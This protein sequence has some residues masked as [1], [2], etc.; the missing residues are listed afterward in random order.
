M[1]YLIMGISFLLLVFVA[2]INIRSQSVK[3]KIHASPHNQKVNNEDKDT[4]LIKMAINQSSLLTQLEE[5]TR[6]VDS[7]DKEVKL[8]NK[9]E[10]R[11][12]HAADEQQ[13]LTSIRT[14]QR[15]ISI[16]KIISEIESPDYDEG[17][18]TYPKLSNEKT[19]GLKGF[20]SKLIE[21][22]SQHGRDG[23]GTSGIKE[24]GRGTA[25]E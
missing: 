12:Y 19:E 11:F 4:L 9:R 17:A 16:T 1:P 24:V 21:E 13:F 23:K 18:V 5:L 7:C 2:I 6:K 22:D 3:R 8:L 14:T 10:I 20:F 15:D 25:R